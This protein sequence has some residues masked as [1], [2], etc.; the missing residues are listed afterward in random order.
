MIVCWLLGFSAPCQ[1]ERLCPY[2]WGCRLHLPSLHGAEHQPWWEVLRLSC[3]NS[4]VTAPGSLSH[5]SAVP[6]HRPHCPPPQLPSVTLTV[7]IKQLSLVS[8][9]PVGLWAPQWL[10]SQ[11]YLTGEPQ[12]H[13]PALRRPSLR[14][15]ELGC[16]LAT[17]KARLPAPYPAS[18]AGG[19]TYAE[20]AARLSPACPIWRP[21]R[22]STPVRNPSAAT[23]AGNASQRPGTW[24]S[25]S[26]FT[27]GR[28]P[29]A[30]TSV[31]RRSP[32]SATWGRT[33]SLPQ[34][35]DHRPGE[36]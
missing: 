32:G 13:F 5:S 3:S 10:R 9:Q 2:L 14:S 30:V 20:P 6:Q 33:S 7:P 29:S 34:A 11:P 27:P 8:A 28:N 17:V 22:G 19:A 36:V 35:V 24:R 12:Q 1:Q 15:I 18:A 31:G 23:P 16:W 26:E 21:T 4:I 25:T